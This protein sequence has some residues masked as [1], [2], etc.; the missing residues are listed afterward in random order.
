MNK[1]LTDH[2]D[3][4]KDDVEQLQHELN[5]KDMMILFKDNEIDRLND[6]CK[7]TW[8]KWQR[9]VHDFDNYR[10]LKENEK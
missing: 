5:N 8:D 6:Q 4:L 7:E 10:T 1:I 3:E 2:I 9:C